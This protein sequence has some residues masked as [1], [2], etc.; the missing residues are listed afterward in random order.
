M[1]QAQKLQQV[2]STLGKEKPPNSEFI[3]PSQ[4][5]VLCSLS[6]D[7]NWHKVPRRDEVQTDPI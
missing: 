3:C 4:V 6:E 5:V 1:K 2:F 7:Q